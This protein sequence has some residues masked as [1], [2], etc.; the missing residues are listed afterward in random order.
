MFR[1]LFR[2]FRACGTMSAYRVLS[3]ASMLAVVG[4]T[5]GQTRGRTHKVRTKGHAQEKQWTPPYVIRSIFVACTLA[6]VS[7]PKV[8]SFT[9]QGMCPFDSLPYMSELFVATPWWQADHHPNR[10]YSRSS[11][12]L[13]NGA[14]IVWPCLRWGRV[15]RQLVA[16][17][18]ALP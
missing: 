5:Y 6:G 8:L 13:I 4:P 16:A 11:W 14:F 1:P 3:Y 7:R 18:V 2:C 10:Q 12:T 9:T 15:V 17:A